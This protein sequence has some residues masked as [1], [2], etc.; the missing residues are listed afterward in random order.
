M[1][2]ILLLH[3]SVGLGHQRAAQALAQA[4][5]QVDGVSVT[6]EDTLD[7]ARP[8]FRRA[9]AGMYLGL[10]GRAPA[11]WSLYYASTNR[12]HPRSQAQPGL[13][14]RFRLLSTSF[15][16]RGLPALLERA[17]PDA[18]VCT[19]FLP[20][21]ALAPLRRYGLPPTYL[22]LTDYHAHQFWALV[23]VDRYF[24][25]TPAAREQLAALGIPRPKIAV[26]GIPVDPAIGQPADRLAARRGL[27]LDPAQPVITLV[28]SGMP[29]DRVRAIAAELLAQRLPAA[30]LVATGR[31][32]DLAASLE[33]LE[34]AAGPAMRVLGPRPSLDPLFVASDLVIGKAGGLT[35]SEV[36]ARG[37]PMIIPTPLP[38]Q[39][40]WN[41]EH[42]VNA[43]AGIR[44][45]TAR[46][47]AQAAAALLDDPR[48]RA[49]MS[50]AA[51]AIGRPQAAPAI[52]ARVLHE[53]GQFRPA[54]QGQAA[55]G[56]K[57][58]AAR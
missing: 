42:V 17:R 30:L 50:R 18:I 40:H 41:A 15:G 57:A 22:V 56:G 51:R 9:Y 25:P 7:H 33:D 2:R 27:G 16:V 28:G 34:R 37:L 44:R 13:Y 36:L 45:G 26:A 3:A 58:W 4:F 31:S 32:R 23:G 53:L 52:A 19:H 48:R 20:I 54:A 1:P 46:E 29:A 49:A 14:E 39:E 8:F 11:F 12:P 35:V 6:I 55:I 10:A 47:I 24:V 38:G 21:E 5:S 43:G